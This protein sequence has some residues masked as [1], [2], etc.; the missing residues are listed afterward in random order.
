[1]TA[2][3]QL[4]R[5]EYG[6]CPH[7]HAPGEILNVGRDHWGVCRRHMVRWRIGSN[8]FSGWQCESEADWSRNV[9]ALAGRQVVQPANMERELCRV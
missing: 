5:S 9:A 3:V 8:L 6:A 7:C 2:V 4:V 1:M